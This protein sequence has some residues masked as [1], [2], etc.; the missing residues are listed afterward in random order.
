MA[1][2][3]SS[4]PKPSWPPTLDDWETAKPTIKGLYMKEGK[5]LR[6]VK[7]EMEAMHNFKAT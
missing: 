6:E 1:T 5:K 4:H 3:V 7:L 2:A